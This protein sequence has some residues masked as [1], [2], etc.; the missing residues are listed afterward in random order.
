LDAGSIPAISTKIQPPYGGFDFCRVPHSDAAP[1][2]RHTHNKKV[3]P[4]YQVVNL[5]Y[6]TASNGGFIFSLFIFD[7][8]LVNYLLQ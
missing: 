8:N 7:E 1:Q 5:K 4:Q 3:I 2:Y 6:K